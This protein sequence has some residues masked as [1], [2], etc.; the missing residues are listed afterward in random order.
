[1]KNSVDRN[2][3]L[4]TQYIGEENAKLRNGS[5][6]AQGSENKRH[7]KLAEIALA[8][9]LNFVDENGNLFD[10]QGHACDIPKHIVENSKLPK[11]FHYDVEIKFY[12]K[13]R[14]Q[15]LLGDVIRK[16]NAMQKTLV[17]LLVSYDCIPQNVSG[18]EVI[19][20]EPTSK[21]VDYFR[22][23]MKIA[24]QVKDRTNSVSE[25]RSMVTEF[26]AQNKEMRFYLNNNSNS[27]T[28]NRQIQICLNL[29]K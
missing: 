8:K 7:G 16:C 23:A 15:L 10:Q 11:E 28:D 17:I 27:K 29:N 20:V 5:L 26:N 21:E 3:A 13:K 19:K 22:K 24:E 6:S 1:M 4:L 14:R 25:T 9:V 12:E 2:I 18:L